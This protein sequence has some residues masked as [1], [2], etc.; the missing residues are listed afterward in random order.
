MKT[1][2]VMT[3]GWMRAKYLKTYAEYYIR[4]L[5]EYAAEGAAINALTTQNESETDQLGLMPACYWHP[6]FE[7][8]FLRDHLLPL[9]KENG[10]EKMEL[11]IMDHNF[12]MWRRAKWML[13]DPTLKAVVR[14]IAW[15]PYEGP[16]SAMEMVHEAHP[17][18]DAHVTELGAGWSLEPDATC[19]DGK[20]FIEI[21]RNWSRSLFCWNLALDETGRPHIGP[22]F[23]EDGAAGGGMI[24]IHSKTRE[25]KYGSQYRAIAHFSRYVKRGARCIGSECDM[26]GIFQVDFRNPDGE[27]VV[28]ISNPGSVANASLVIGDRHAQVRMSAVSLNTL[29]FR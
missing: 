21:M 20:T 3:G 16:S 18:I 6:E 5:K 4:Y 13:D 25:I 8:E 2:G 11:W 15:H 7:A 26:G 23:H 27:Y 29:I 10:L 9:L 12:I 17:E 22:F 19:M 24:Q 1:G 28:I 14:G